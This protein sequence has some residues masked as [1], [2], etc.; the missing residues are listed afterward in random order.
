MKGQLVGINT[1]ILAPDRGS[2]GIG[3]A[4]PVNMVKSVML[5]L[6]EYGNVKRGVLGIGAQD[7]T[8][9]LASAFKIGA[10]QGAAVTQV[11]PHSP[12]QH[13]GIQV[14]DII[15]T[16]NGNEVK[17][18]SDVVN[19][20]GFLRVDSKINITVL[21]NNKTI[22]IS[23]TLS[24]SKKRTQLIA[25]MNPFLYGVGL[26]NFNV[27]SPVHGNVQGVLVTA[28]D[29]DSNSWHSDLRPGDVITSINQ[30]KVNNIE[31]LK[32]ITPKAGKELLL[33]VL[34]GP[35][36]VFLVINKEES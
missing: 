6:I 19:T 28:V 4:I 17:T 5:Q 13:A 24:D 36:A 20:I 3:F 35:G 23:V 33:N 12:A 1:A 30:Q 29:K 26:K 11:L 22:P 14:G 8:P 9:E 21:R 31:E 18:A 7:I 27:L 16:A 10:I 2:V 34:R 25:Q 15:T 32:A